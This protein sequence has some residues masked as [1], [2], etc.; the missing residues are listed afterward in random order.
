MATVQS[1]FSDS[2]WHAIGLQSTSEHCNTWKLHFSG[3]C[4]H[5]F[6]VEDMQSRRAP[7]AVISHANVGG[8]TNGRFKVCTSPSASLAPGWN[9]SRVERRLG[10]IL[11]STEG[12]LTVGDPSLHSH[13]RKRN[14]SGVR[15]YTSA[16]RINTGTAS[17]EVISPCVLNRSGFVRRVMTASEL[18]DAFDVQVAL[19]SSLLGSPCLSLV[20]DYVVATAPEKITSA[21]VRHLN[22]SGSASTHPATAKARSTTAPEGVQWLVDEDDQALN[23]EQAARNDDWAP[24]TSQW[25]TYIVQNFD[26]PSE[27]GDFHAANPT[28]CTSIGLDIP[29]LQSS[30][31]S[32]QEKFQMPICAFSLVFGGC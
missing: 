7:G 9:Q 8:V 4:Q 28:F 26:A 2:S 27:W 12:G 24:D 6:T 11:R 32:T 14:R 23:D 16:M 15:V 30:P 13:H 29:A 3:G 17:V 5:I 20:L 18:F 19:A 21:V 1:E 10:H 25:N 31:P 22:L